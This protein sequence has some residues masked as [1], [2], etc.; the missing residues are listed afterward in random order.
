MLHNKL[1]KELF[2]CCD[3][4]L[5]VLC[6]KRLLKQ[7]CKKKDNCRLNFTDFSRFISNFQLLLFPENKEIIWNLFS[8][9]NFFKVFQNFPEIAEFPFL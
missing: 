2:V 3:H 5:L 8:I 7:K 1:S 9:A 4:S 6:I